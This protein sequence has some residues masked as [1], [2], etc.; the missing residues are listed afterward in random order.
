MKVFLYN[1]KIHGRT[2]GFSGARLCVDRINRECGAMINLYRDESFLNKRIF[3]L[4]GSDSDD[5]FVRE[6]IQFLVHK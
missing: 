1:P 5:H 4:I 2:L 3:D 6:A